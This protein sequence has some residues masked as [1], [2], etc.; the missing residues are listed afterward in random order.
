MKTS[1]EYLAL[2]PSMVAE[3]VCLM[4]YSGP[5]QTQIEYFRKNMTEGSQKEFVKLCDQRCR[6]AYNA[7]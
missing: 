1:Y 6:E 5:E 3:Q 2:L 7:E 4:P